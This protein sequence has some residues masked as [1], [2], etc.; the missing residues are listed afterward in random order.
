MFWI[1]VKGVF[2]NGVTGVFVIGVTGV[3]GKSVTGEF[4][5]G[6]NSGVLNRCNRCVCKSLTHQL[7]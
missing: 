1:G 5:I 4:G 2:G 3:F 7:C 6:F